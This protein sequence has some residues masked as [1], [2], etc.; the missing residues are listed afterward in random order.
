[1]EEEGRE[2]GRGGRGRGLG[3]GGEEGGERRRGEGRRAQVEDR[4]DRQRRQ[5]APGQ[6]ERRL[7]VEGGERDAREGVERDEGEEELPHDRQPA[8]EQQRVDRP[9]KA[10][11]ERRYCCTGP[12][13]CQP[14]FRFAPLAL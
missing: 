2:C 4:A 10:A 13:V 9:E 6:E 5:Q 8:G 14:T 12:R 3:P 11:H 7:A 1:G